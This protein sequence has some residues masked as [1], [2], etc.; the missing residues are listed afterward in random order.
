MSSLGFHPAGISAIR[1][2]RASWCDSIFHTY[3]ICFDKMWHDASSRR[4]KTPGSCHHSN[5][6][7][8]NHEFL[9]SISSIAASRLINIHRMSIKYDEL[10]PEHHTI[11]SISKELIFAL[12]VEYLSSLATRNYIDKRHGGKPG[13]FLKSIFVLLGRYYR[14]LRLCN[15]V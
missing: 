15:N 10:S 9:N 14:R 13:I 1:S 7:W 8:K 3:F 4:L 2:F 5:A 11:F 12:C 6:H